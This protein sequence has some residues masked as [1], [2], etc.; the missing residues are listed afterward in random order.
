MRLALRDRAAPAESRPRSAAEG[1]S[2][3]DIEEIALSN[4]D[5]FSVKMLGF[6]LRI[7]QI[8]D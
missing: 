8:N 5:R 3:R 6:R 7:K 4:I 1:R 2:L